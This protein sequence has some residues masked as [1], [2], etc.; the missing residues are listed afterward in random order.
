MITSKNDISNV[1]LYQSAM[2]TL[3]LQLSELEEDFFTLTEG[4]DTEIQ[5]GTKQP[6]R[7]LNRHNFVVKC[8]EVWI[9]NWI[10]CKSFNQILVEEPDEVDSEVKST[11]E[12]IKQVL[13]KRFNIVLESTYDGPLVME[14]TLLVCLPPNE[15]L[16]D[17]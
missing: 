1:S 13:K 4:R 11:F 8:L 10:N 6:A 7:Q 2:K 16:F 9:E 5:E 17:I 15:D 3:P 12:R 14:E